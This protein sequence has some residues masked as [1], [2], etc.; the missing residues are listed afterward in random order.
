ME[1]TASLQR[2]RPVGQAAAGA[3][4]SVPANASGYEPVTPT[5]LP[6]VLKVILALLPRVAMAAM[7]TTMINASMTAYSTAVGPSSRLRKLTKLEEIQ[8]NIINSQKNHIDLA[9]IHENPSEL[10]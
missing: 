2:E 9:K 4:I 5:A 10:Q 1:R 8:E 3:S 6:T 7:Q